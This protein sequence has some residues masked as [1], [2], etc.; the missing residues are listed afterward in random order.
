MKKVLQNESVSGWLNMIKTNSA[1]NMQNLAEKLLNPGN[2]HLSETAKKHLRWLYILYH[3]QKGNV[4]K[5]SRK[6]GV[7][8]QWLSGL[9]QKFEHNN[10][11]PR[12]LEPLSRAPRNTEKRVA[13]PKKIEKLIIKIR[14]DSLNVWGKKK[15]SE[16]LRITY[17]IKVSPNTVNKYL[18]KYKRISPKISL[19]NIRKNVKLSNS[20]N[21]DATGG[22]EGKM[23]NIEN[24]ATES[25]KSI[26]I[27][28]GLKPKNYKKVL[29]GE[30][31]PHTKVC[32]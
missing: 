25:V 14:D 17:K 4:S 6:A 15:I 7:S 24:L 9:K 1:K 5:A 3:D 27:F 11:D 30:K 28:N 19:K 23:K 10:K 20:H 32:K 29:L 13:I 26:E 2:Y 8:R 31:F 12:C 21:I 18:H 16:E 22:M